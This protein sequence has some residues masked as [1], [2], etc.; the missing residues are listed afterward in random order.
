MSGASFPAIFERIVARGGQADADTVRA[1]FDA[2]LDGA[3]TP[4]QIGAFAGVLRVHGASTAALVAGA[5]ALRA[6]MTAV[7]HTFPDAIDTCGTGGDGRGTVNVSTASAVLL[8][9]L[10]VPVAKHGNRSVS[11]RSGSADVLESLGLALDVPPERQT[12]VLHEVGIAF[13]LAPAH[14]PALRHASVARRELGVKTLFNAL[15]PLANPA[16]VP[17]QLVG[18]YE[19]DL[20]PKM[21]AALGELGVRRAWVVRSCD[22]TDEISPEAATRVSVLHPSGEVEERTISPE[23]F[24]LLS[25]PLADLD[26]GSPDENADALRALFRGEDTP[27]RHAIV[28]NAAAALHLARDV[29]LVEAARI[30]DAARREGRGQT[31]L[32]RWIAAA[33]TRRPTP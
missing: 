11:S 8:A 33:A 17:V 25:T 22:G 2:I 13:L 16:S 30:V 19:D 5:R 3:W 1:A 10:G 18:V 27:A 26:G 14:H 23:D 9:A 6:A 12:E 15:G 28:L 31:V 20:R 29:P 24:G 21:A 7:A 32:T 4:V